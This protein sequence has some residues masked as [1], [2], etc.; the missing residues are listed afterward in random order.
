MTARSFRVR[1]VADFDEW[2]AWLRDGMLEL[3]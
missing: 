1:I 2:R 3:A